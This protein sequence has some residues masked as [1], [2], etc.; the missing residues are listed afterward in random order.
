MRQLSPNF[1]KMFNCFPQIFPSCSSFQFF[2]DN[3]V[4]SGVRTRQIVCHNFVNIWG[5]QRLFGYLGPK[6]SRNSRVNFEHFQNFMIPFGERGECLG[7]L[8]NV[9]R[10]FAGDLRSFTN[11]ELTEK[12]SP[13]V[14]QRVPNKLIALFPN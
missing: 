12:Q 4:N 11:L 14:P 6:G 10:K 2:W 13:K 8:G 5:K 9:C 1:R 7:R 3:L